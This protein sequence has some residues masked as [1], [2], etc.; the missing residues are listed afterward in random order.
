MTATIILQLLEEGLVALDD[1]VD[2]YVAGVPDGDAITIA[3]L[4]DMRSGL[5][6][7]VDDLEYR[8]T[9]GS[10]PTRVRTPE[11]LLDVAFAHP[12][13]Q[14][15]SR[16]HYSNTNY[17]LL[18]LIMETVT[19]KSATALF[20]ERVFEPLGMD[21][22]SLPD[23]DDLAVPGP[24]A[25][26]YE[27][28]SDLSRE[29]QTEAAEAGTLLPEDRTEFSPS[30]WTAGGM[31]STADDLVIWADALVDGLLLN[32]YTQLVRLA[33]IQLDPSNPELGYGYGISKFGAYL[34][35]G[36][37]VPGYSS[38]IGCDRHTATTVVVLAGLSFAPDGAGVAAELA[39][40]VTG[41][42]QKY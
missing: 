22:S 15:G 19:G 20:D 42:I 11:E 30:D 10:D 8:F 27:Y 35:H 34:G 28:D 24:Y 41:V 13:Y 40:A 29:A 37:I 17:I 31:I 6:N 2:E 18:G 5:F 23:A 12:S 16:F 7:Y 32:E 21:D 36:G 1:P 26:G 14:V 4:L 3:D 38:Y 39:I 9:L 25:H 33:S